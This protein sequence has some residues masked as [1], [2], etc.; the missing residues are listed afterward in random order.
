MPSN[1]KVPVLQF[2]AWSEIERFASELR[3]SIPVRSP[4]LY[5][6]AR[7]TGRFDNALAADPIDKDIIYIG[8][9]TSSLRARLTKFWVALNG[10]KGHSGGKRTRKTYGDYFG[11]DKTSSASLYV[12]YCA[13]FGQLDRQKTGDHFYQMGMVTLLEYQLLGDWY[14]LHGRT[15]SCNAKRR[16]EAA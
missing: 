9:T 3:L 4:G 11:R 14:R 13:P 1:F 12:A 5:L 6:V 15:P 10:G 16:G 2:S 8:M 7:K